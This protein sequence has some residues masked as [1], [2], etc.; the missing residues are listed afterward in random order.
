MIRTFIVV[1]TFSFSVL[2]PLPGIAQDTL[3]TRTVLRAVAGRVLNDTKFL[4]VNVKTGER[5][6]SPGAAPAGANVGV[7]S[8]TFEAGSRTV[9]WSAGTVASDIYYAAFT[10]HDGRGIPRYRTARGLVVIR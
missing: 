1:F 9:T 6:N 8:G 2:S 4:F 7:A 5:Y 3:R 10:A